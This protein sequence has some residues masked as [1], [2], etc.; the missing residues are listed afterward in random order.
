MI[1]AYV[2][3]LGRRLQ[4]PRRVKVDLLSEARDALF[5][6]ASAYERGGIV[7]PAAEARAVTEFGSV[8]EIG[9]LY[10]AELA[11]SQ[12]RRTA[13]SLFFILMMQAAA[14]NL[15]W[16]E[17]RP[18]RPAEPTHLATAVSSAVG[19]LAGIAL[20]GS[21]IATLACGVGVRRLSGACGEVI[22]ATGTF[23]LVVAVSLTALSSVL[24]VVSSRPESL[25]SLS[26]GLPWTL[27][28]L[29]VPM[30]SVAV[31]GRRCLAVAP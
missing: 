2:D 26:V 29:L 25:L 18:A 11:F 24:A 22:R 3:E 28:F 21:L 17:I 6:A 19:W 31:S 5:D 10:Q 14:W 1:D 16:P 4:G 7:R 23:A 8:D 30:A 20:I 15:V 9:P 12:G 13:L 27:A